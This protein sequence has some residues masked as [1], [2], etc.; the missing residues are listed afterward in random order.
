VGL[1]VHAWPGIRRHAASGWAAVGHDGDRSSDFH[2]RPRVHQAVCS[3]SS[4][5]CYLRLHCLGGGRDDDLPFGVHSHVAELE[6]DGRRCNLLL[7]SIYHQHREVRFA[8]RSYP[9]KKVTRIYR[10]THPL[11]IVVSVVIF[12]AIWM[13]LPGVSDS[14][15]SVLLAALAAGC[16]GVGIVHLHEVVNGPAVLVVHDK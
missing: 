11:T 3:Q 1:R 16:L 10:I 14:W 12:L 7:R 6:A 8:I 2:L 9:M 4:L 13:V 5:P 15:M